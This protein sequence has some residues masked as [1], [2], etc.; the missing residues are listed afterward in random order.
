[1]SGPKRH[2]RIRKF[3]ID[4]SRA[5]KLAGDNDDGD[6]EYVVAFTDESYIHQN[7][8][9]LTSWVKRGT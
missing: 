6:E 3:M 7:H 5:L 9:R 4:M 1:M 2:M 8:S